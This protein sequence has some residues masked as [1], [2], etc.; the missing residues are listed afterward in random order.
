MN[1]TSH[2]TAR[3][4]TLAVAMVAVA[5]AAFAVSASAAAAP[6][7]VTIGGVEGTQGTLMVA[8]YD[9][10]GYRTK[11]VRAA[12]QPAASPVFRFDLPE[13]EYAIAAFHDRNDNGKLDTNLMGVPT[14]PYGFSRHG[15]ATMGPPGWAD[16]KFELPSGGA[17]IGVQLSK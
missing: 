13:G 17:R 2:C 8:V 7:E 10:A 16:A 1:R 6:L 12:A 5:A 9:A 3:A 14:E 4:A 15:A 11:S